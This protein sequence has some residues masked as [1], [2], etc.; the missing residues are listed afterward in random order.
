MSLENYEE[1]KE[2]L[3]NRVYT[4]GQVAKICELSLSTI[5]RCIDS[6]DLEG[7]RVPGSTH[8]RI[9]HDSLVEFMKKYEI[10]EFFKD[11]FN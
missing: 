10:Y 6:R 8:R 11:N 2:E 9:T 1:F 4:T 5:I 3:F 7:Y